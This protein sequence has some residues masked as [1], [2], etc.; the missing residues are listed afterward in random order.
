MKQGLRISQEP[1]YSQKKKQGIC[2][3]SQ[4]QK[5]HGKG[6]LMCYKH[7]RQNQKYNNPLRYWFDVLRQNARSRKI[8]FKLTIEQFKI[9]CE[10][11]GYL[12]LKGKGANDL[13]IDRRDN[14]RGYEFDNIRVLTL[15]QNSRKRWIDEKIRF[16]GY[17]T[18]EERAEFYGDFDPLEALPPIENKTENNGDD[19]EEFPF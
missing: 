6:F 9:F 7:V 15:A 2:V 10:K 4:C 5:K 18:P 13:S 17:L 8:D 3:V 12:E 14:S 19:Y 16:G 1:L 11:T